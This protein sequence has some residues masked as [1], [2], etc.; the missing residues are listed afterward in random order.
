MGISTKIQS[1]NSLQVFMMLKVMVKYT[2]K[3]MMTNYEETAHTCKMV[4]IGACVTCVNPC[5]KIII[6]SAHY[7]AAASCF[8]YIY[9]DF[10]IGAHC[11]FEY[12][13]VV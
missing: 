4:W 1:Q 11:T 5:I 13:L 7:L 10:P 2:E 3:L 6:G 8:L 12:L 9:L